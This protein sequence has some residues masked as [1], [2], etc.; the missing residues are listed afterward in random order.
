M[1]KVE[2]NIAKQ[3]IYIIIDPGSS[4]IYVTL[5][6]VENCLLF[7][8]KHDKSWLVKLAMGTKRKVCEVVMEFPLE[9]NGLFTKAYRN[10][11]LLG[12]YDPSLAWTG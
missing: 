11:L 2:G 8:K 7:K 6:I 9:L 12:S 10:V 3:S 1:I 4:H 5:R